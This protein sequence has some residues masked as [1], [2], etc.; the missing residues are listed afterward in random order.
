[1][2]TLYNLMQKKEY[3]IPNDILI[4]FKD[5]I[6][7]GEAKNEPSL[8]HECTNDFFQAMEDHLDAE[9]RY[10][11]FEKYGGCMG[12]GQDGARKTFA[13][14]HILMPLEAKIELFAKKFC[15]NVVLNK[16][17]TISINFTCSH[18]YFKRARESKN[19]PPLPPIQ[20]YFERCAG[21]RLYEL[22]KAL[23]IKLKI[24]S[25][26]ISSLKENLDNPVVYTFD[27]VNK[28]E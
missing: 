13:S 16:D 25:I 15:R 28:F 19:P 8:D 20:S 23:G 3:N 11:I 5:I 2:K 12:T 1:M 17:N 26:D 18:G 6:E 10:R 27:I 9:Q 4:I 24:K 22:Q 21:G 7:K 14:E